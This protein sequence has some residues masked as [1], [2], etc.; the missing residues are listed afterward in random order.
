MK[1]E[2]K[3]VSKELR[4]YFYDGKRLLSGKIKS[5]ILLNEKVTNKN[6]LNSNHI[7]VFTDIYEHKNNNLTRQPEKMF[8]VKKDDIYI[9]KEGA[10]KRT[11]GYLPTKSVILEY[12]EKG[13][14]CL[15]EEKN[16][17]KEVTIRDYDVIIDETNDFSILYHFEENI[18]PTINVFKK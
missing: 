10:L 18:E 16:E 17:F 9:T 2:F 7:I 14:V 1:K 4:C 6:N 5:E 3:A 13:S 15:I 12:F 8:F 11:V